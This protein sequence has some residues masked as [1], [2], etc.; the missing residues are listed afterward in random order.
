MASLRARSDRGTSRDS[1]WS[2]SYGSSQDRSDGNTYSRAGSVQM[3]NIPPS[4]PG[5]GTGADLGF[6]VGDR[7]THDKYG[8]GKVI[9]LEGTG[10]NAAAKVDFGADGVKRLILR[11][12]PIAKL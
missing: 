1:A 5:V 2:S 8:M 4:P 9:A 6:E 7:V 11:F 12:A 10:K 3:R